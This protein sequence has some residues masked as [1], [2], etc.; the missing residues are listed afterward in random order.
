MLLVL[1]NATT[2]FFLVPIASIREV[3]EGPATDA[4]T[5]CPEVYAESRCFSIIHGEDFSTLDLV[6]PTQEES[7]HWTVGLRYLLAKKSGMYIPY[8]GK[9]KP[10]G[11]MNQ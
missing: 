4:F 11:H 6:F 8:Q 7:L 10:E 9:K 2:N 1:L 5:Q 3:R